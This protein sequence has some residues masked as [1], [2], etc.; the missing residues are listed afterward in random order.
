MKKF[1]FN[2]KGFKTE[3]KAFIGYETFIISGIIIAF[4]ISGIVEVSWGKYQPL[5]WFVKVFGFWA[6]PLFWTILYLAIM[7][8]FR[9]KVHRALISKLS[10]IL[11]FVIA[12]T[13]M[14]NTKSGLLGTY[15]FKMLNT[16][17]NEVWFW[18][19]LSVVLYAV[20]ISLMLFKAPFTL[21]FNFYNLIIQIVSKGKKLSIKKETKTPQAMQKDATVIVEG[22]MPYTPIKEV[23]ET[24]TS[25]KPTGYS[26]K[27]KSIFDLIDDGPIEEAASLETSKNNRKTISPSISQSSKNGQKPSVKY[28]VPSKELLRDVVSNEKND[29]NIASAKYTS[30]PLIMVLSEFNIPA[31]I[32]NIIVGP[33]ITRYELKIPSHIKVSK[34]TSL[35]DN[36]KMML[37]ARSIRIQAPI[38]GKAL[39][40]IEIPNRYTSLVDFKSV[41]KDQP[42]NQAKNPLSVVLGKNIEGKSAWLEIN[43]TPHMLVAGATGSGKSVCINTIL[44][45]I[46]LHATP[47]Q[48]RLLLIDPKMVEFTPFKG[49]PHLLAPIITDPTEAM[50]ALAQVVEDMQ[51]RYKLLAEFGVRKIEDYNDKVPKS[52]RLPFII[53]IIDE[54]ADLM[55]AA[56]KEVETSIARITQKA[57][58]AGIHL[59]VSTQRPSTDIVTGLIKSNIPTR[60]SFAVPT[61]IDSRTILDS[62]GAE[63][64]L[65]KGDML[66]KTSG[67]GSE[68]YQGA[69][70]GEEELESIISASKAQAEP[71][72]SELYLNLKEKFSSGISSSANASSDALFNDVK[73][74]VIETQKASSSLLQRKFS[75]GYGRAA[76][77]IDALEAQGVVGPAR[78]SKPRDVLIK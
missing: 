10:S 1:N 52:Q 65:G 24:N 9:R 31:K 27:V 50:F 40:G 62:P 49:I 29:K 42:K 5:T 13:I 58:A 12:S 23:E 22:N 30:E 77:L 48:V 66:V 78:G 4:A 55:M 19:L 45:S 38:P 56:S 57:R 61:S 21:L 68:R 76:R 75:I 59:I 46:L 28:K 72:Y 32:E 74:F 16:I 25:A 37:Q 3:K 67:T 54:L 63:K 71:S 8:F 43:K 73:R 7:E 6:K 26:K 18:K 34:I 14:F 2:S 69:F 53:I 60:I 64:L 70:I 11:I 41:I 20:S 17:I 51:S 39:I 47:Y 44:A 36:I 33:S 35:E 15:T